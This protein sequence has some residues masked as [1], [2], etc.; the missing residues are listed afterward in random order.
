MLN[1][2][3][4]ILMVKGVKSD[5]PTAK[6]KSHEAEPARRGGQNGNGSTRKISR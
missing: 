6:A 3:S 4:S 5:V 2:L 1:H